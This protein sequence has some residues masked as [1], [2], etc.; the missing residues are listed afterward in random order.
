MK[1]TLS[2][3]A[4]ILSLSTS[5]EA[6]PLLVPFDSVGNSSEVV[7]EDES[8]SESSQEL[9]LYYM[10]SNSKVSEFAYDR[11]DEILGASYV[12]ILL[13]QVM[14]LDLERNI[15]ALKG[16]LLEKYPQA[17]R[18]KA[19]ALPFESIEAKWRF[20]DSHFSELE[21]A[22]LATDIASILLPISIDL[23]LSESGSEFLMRRV[24][25]SSSIGKISAT[26][27]FVQKTSTSETE[28]STKFVVPVS[29]KG[30]ASC[31]MTAVG[32]DI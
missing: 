29:V 22:D 3:L 21:D 19:L 9:I 24:K 13:Q 18:V 7:W 23:P 6:R 17:L 8:N 12:Q 4:A 20:K 25:Q 31:E 2:I 16:K 10:P 15:E 14:S 28:I 26:V 5:L 30:V 32:C 1:S 11:N 27:R